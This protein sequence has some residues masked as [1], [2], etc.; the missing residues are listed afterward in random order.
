[1]VEV[2]DWIRASLMALALP[3]AVAL[4]KGRNPIRV[5]VRVRVRNL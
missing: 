4:G 3:R 2:R 1:M 5:T